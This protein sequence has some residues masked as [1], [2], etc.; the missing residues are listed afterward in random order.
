MSRRSRTPSWPR[1]RPT[2]PTLL[3]S[4]L[5]LPRHGQQKEGTRSP[6]SQLQRGRSSKPVLEVCMPPS[7][8]WSKY[9]RIW[10][11]KGS[12]WTHW[13]GSSRNDSSQSHSTPTRPTSTSP[14]SWWCPSRPSVSCPMGTRPMQLLKGHHHL[15]GAV[16]HGPCNQQEP[17]QG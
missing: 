10:M 14:L 16:A 1:S 12:H 9:I 3:H 6:I 2:T 5:Q 7:S 17:G 13:D 4:K 8:R 11:P 15:C